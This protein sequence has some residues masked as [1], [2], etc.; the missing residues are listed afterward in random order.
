MEDTQKNNRK[1]F[2]G[3]KEEVRNYQGRN[4]VFGIHN[5]PNFY[6]YFVIHDPKISDNFDP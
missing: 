3:W 4:E 6:L 1:R 2:I 5:D